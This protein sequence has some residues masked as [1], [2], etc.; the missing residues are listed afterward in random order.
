MPIAPNDAG[1]VS[2]DGKFFRLGAKKF[3]IKG[4]TYGPFA[5][6]SD[7]ETFPGK[8]RTASD[9]QKILELGANLVRT[10]YVP[11]R[12][13]LDL[14]QEHDLKVMVDIPWPKHLCF[15]DSEMLRHNA[16]DAMRHAALECKNH[17][18]LFAYSVVNEIPA[19]IVRWSGV[20]AINEFI[21]SLIEEIRQ[22]DPEAL[23]TFASYPPTEFLEVKNADFV[24]FN[25][26]LHKQKN[27]E[28]YL[29]RLQMLADSKPLLLGEFGIDSIHE[30]DDQQCE[31]LTWEIETVFR[32]GLTG[33]IIFSFTD[34]W[35]RGGMQILDWGF[36]LTTADRKP[37]PAF[38]AVQ[39]MFAAAPYFPLPR[40]PKVSVVV[41]SYNGARTL[42]I[43]LQSLTKLNYPNYEVVLVDDGSTDSSPDIA[44]EFK[45]IRY[46]RQK[47][48]G[49]SV[50][51]NT[52]IKAAT[53]EIVAFTDSDCR[54]D[55]DWLYYLI[56]DLLQSEFAAMGGHNFLPP[57]DSWIATAVMV[58]PGGPAHVMLSDHEAEHIPGCNMAFYKWALDGIGGFDPVFTKAGDDVDVCWRIQQAG[59]KIGFSPSGFVWHYRRSTTEAYLKQQ[60]GYGEAEALLSRKHP[61]YFNLLGG[62]IWHGRIYT[63]AKFGVMLRRPVIYHGLFGSG[64]FQKL[65]NPAPASL[66]MLFTTLEYHVLVTLPLLVLSSSFPFLLPVALTSLGLSI[67]VCVAAAIQAEIPQKK[68]QFWS[69]PLVALLFF[70]QPIVRGFA[71]YQWRITVRSMPERVSDRYEGRARSSEPPPE[72]LSYWSS[73][74]VD[75][76]DLL[77]EILQKLGE[78]GW[79]HKTDTGWS[80]HDVEIFGN[81]WSRLFLTTVAED[82][83]GGKRV[84]RC[85]LKSAWSLSAKILFFTVFAV[86][87]LVVSLLVRIQPWFWML[88]PTVAILGW[89]LEQQ[90]KGLQYLIGAL[91]D[92]VAEN[93]GMIRLEKEN[94]LSGPADKA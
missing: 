89:M 36:G 40:Y 81:I 78:L 14:A 83:E 71:R 77:K 5:P 30:G 25:V 39:K 61:E 15:L 26:Y 33:T 44:S 60:R 75:R 28:N 58:S 66:L 52:G 4:V 93:R 79:Q 94:I 65:Y 2:V 3:F 37:K 55:E 13:F 87:I 84:F 46:I 47:N 50:A 45:S 38:A 11:P 86:E 57:E 49:L 92:Q 22:I 73:H 54:A 90:T 48:F 8:S 16:R 23:C 18:A 64:F 21:E 67:G 72:K 29:G 7:G 31:I 80:N 91:V 12:W 1:R 41:A 76:Y 62:S 88:L 42:K 35:H 9:F 68:R 59:L 32:M 53:G 74:Y 43:C 70:L 82:L 19:E 34:D 17:P 24:C 27:F 56:S 69:K 85:R 20:R 63:A 10:Y 51:R 6:N